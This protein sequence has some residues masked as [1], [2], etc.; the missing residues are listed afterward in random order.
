MRLPRVRSQ[1][2]FDSKSQSALRVGW[3]GF[4]VEG[5]RAL[6]SVLQRGYRVQA[7][8]TLKSEQA[9]KRS[10]AAS[11]TD[12]CRAF[13]VPLYEVANINDDE[14]RGLLEKLALDIVF[15]IGWS[16]IV[17]AETLR[18]ARVGMIGAHAS[19]LPLNRGRAPIN[20]AL[21]KGAKQTGNT[22]IWLAEGV[23]RGDMIDQTVIPITPYDTCA[24]LY[25][26]VAES[27]SDMILRA[28][29]HLLAGEQPGRAQPHTDAPTL[30]GRRPQD[31]LV[32]WSLSNAEVYDFARALTRPYPGAFGWLDGKR[33][34][35]W[36][37]AL[38]PGA[39]ALKAAP[40]AVIGS[41]FSPVEEACGQAVAC[42]KGA[43]VLL[44][45]E[46]ED[47]EILKGRRLSDQVW[48]GKVWASR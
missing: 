41:V 15:V 14:S 3:I 9:A 44:E 10:G 23:D 7:V 26:R 11:Y 5:V 25:D 20:W 18:L 33:W 31:G 6:R 17:R 13:D 36:Q 32:E 30:P 45:I 38:L 43:V 8:I 40:G 27:N 34:I 16:Q 28:L 19:L 29:P 22:L 4:H 47:G 21:I 1:Q 2:G 46:D 37:S 12:P 39:C 35:I 24:S 48:E 42:G